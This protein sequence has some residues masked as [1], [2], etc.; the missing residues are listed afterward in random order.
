MGTFWKKLA[1]FMLKK[2]RI[3]LF[4]LIS[5]DLCIFFMHFVYLDR[6]N[7]ALKVIKSLKPFKIALPV[8]NVQF[9]LSIFL[10]VL[11]MPKCFSG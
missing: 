1:G 10:Q 5:V 8:R 2:E 6:E 11:L 3:M 4:H 7:R 9:Q